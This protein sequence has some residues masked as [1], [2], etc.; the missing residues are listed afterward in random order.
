MKNQLDS[1]TTSQAQVSINML[2][3]KAKV[4]TLPMVAQKLVELCK[5]DNATFS[6]FARVISSDPGLAARILQ[7]VNSAYFGLRRKATTLDYAIGILGLKYVKTVTLGFHLATNLHKLGCDG[8]NMAE[9]WRENL[10]R[11]T[12]ARQL[13]HRYCPNRLEEAFLIGLLQDCGIPLLVQAL[14]EKY[15]LL[16][17]DCQGSPASLFQLEQEVFEFDH[18]VAAAALTKKW[19]LPDMLS[20]PIRRHHLKPLSA[21]STDE[22][23]QLW[24]IAYFVGTLSLVKPDSV[25]PEDLTLLEFCRDVFNIEPPDLYGLL[26][27]SK[28]EFSQVSQLFREILPER[29]DITDLL[30]QAKDLLSDLASVETCRIFCLEEEVSRLRARCAN[31]SSSVDEFA[32]QA[33]TDNLT[34]LYLRSR[35][36]RFLDDA[37]WKVK[38]N[39]TTLTVIF[40][41]IDDFKDIND[42][43][44]HAVGDRLLKEL[45]ELLKSTFVDN[46]CICRYGGDEFVMA[47][48]GL[49][50]KQTVQSATD[51]AEKIRQLKIPVRSQ[52]GSAHIGFTTSIGVIFCETG[53]QPGNGSWVQ[54]L[55]DTQMYEIKK[56]GKN[57]VRFQVISASPEN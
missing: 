51:L 32:Q 17:S 15:A 53:S 20:R 14:G 29:L 43:H 45:A 7:V 19:A 40:L 57:N 54:E 56:N 33:E 41:D 25:S 30:A 4:P 10:L 36:E 44:S 48:L 38:N 24:Q 2:L 12:L 6:D 16:W 8:F 31:L 42:R 5:D 18:L 21:P 34:G 9:F 13:A 23:E 11:G 47:L 55:A 46:S 49:P 39:E 37:C 35:M 3:D 52:S 26:K 50:L 27:K 1:T 22:H 28:E